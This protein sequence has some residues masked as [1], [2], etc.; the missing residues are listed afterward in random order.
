[1]DTKTTLSYAN[2][3]TSVIDSIDITK[4]SLELLMSW[5]VM[6]I[7]SIPRKNQNQFKTMKLEISKLL[8]SKSFPRAKLSDNDCCSLITEF[9]DKLYLFTNQSDENEVEEMVKSEIAEV[10]P[11]TDDINLLFHLYHSAVQQWWQQTG[12]VPYQTKD[13]VLFAN[14]RSDIQRNSWLKNLHDISMNKMQMF[15]VDFDLDKIGKEY[16][17][18]IDN[19]MKNKIALL[20]VVSNNQALSCLKLLQY[21]TSRSY[22]FSYINS[23][24][25]NLSEF[26]SKLATDINCLIL[27]S[28]RKNDNKNIENLQKHVQQIFFISEVDPKGKTRSFKDMNKGL[29]DLSP[30]SQQKIL[31]R[32]VFFQG[33]PVYL[34]TL[35][36]EKLD[37][38]NE[39]TL[40][41]LLME[42]AIDILPASR[43]KMKDDEINYYVERNLARWLFA[44]EIL[45]EESFKVVYN[46]VID[47]FPEDGK[48]IVV[49]CVSD[50]IKRQIRR[51]F[52]RVKDKEIRLF[53]LKE[54]HDYFD[55][56]CKKY[57][58]RKIHL[59]QFVPVNSKKTVLQ[60]ERSQNSIENIYKYAYTGDVEIKVESLTDA[61]KSLVIL[62]A[63]PG[64]GKS[65]YLTA[66][67][68][69]VCVCATNQTG[70][71]GRFLQI[72]LFP[73]IFRS[74]FYTCK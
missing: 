44:D 58:I 56:I 6:P 26:C 35:L 34:H 63:E 53:M 4:N 37:L 42:D 18:Q 39:Q 72:E 3:L 29:V 13:S 54:A 73:C 61:E 70:P 25:I 17:E 15:D 30:K 27:N 50:K 69:C 11:H 22:N 32:K 64:V 47:E 46:Q 49:V 40:Y 57:P 19:F 24:I 60:W 59:L 67:C 21:L 1:M 52:T 65:T 20:H 16:Q 7:K 12:Q 14:A 9:F 62:A 8:Q 31:N 71:R 38:V 41:T 74:T 48:D 66:M 23:E 55:S 28:N 33:T 68:V 43:S 45:D 36:D 10:Y 51:K 5:N 2:F